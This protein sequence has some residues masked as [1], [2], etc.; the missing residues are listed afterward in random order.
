MPFPFFR[1]RLRRKSLVPGRYLTDG[2]GLFRV[3]SCFDDSRSL[4]VVIEDCV[5]LETH[6]CA[7]LEL[8]AMR[9][10]RVRNGAAVPAAEAQQRYEA[11]EADP[12]LGTRSVGS[13]RSRA[14][15][16]GWPAS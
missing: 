8:E 14:A 16:M 4:L 5:T 15:S 3:L 12:A 13:D 10:R 9:F 6:A 11:T 2:L 7:A 1:R